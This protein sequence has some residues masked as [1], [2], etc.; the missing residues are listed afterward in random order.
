MDTV[1]IYSITELKEQFPEGYERAYEKWKEYCW[2]DIFW[3]DEIVESFKKTFEYAGISIYDWSLGAYSSCHVRFHNPS[4][5]EYNNE[6]DCDEE[7]EW[8]EL[9]GKKAIDWLNEAFDIFSFEKVDYQYDGKNYQRIDFKK[10]GGEEWSCEFT[11]YC[12]DHD[13]LESLYFEILSGSNLKDAFYNLPSVCGKLL[14]Q[15]IEN[16]QSEDYFL[17]HAEANEY[18]YFENGKRYS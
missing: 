10:K 5:Y 11:G 6:E 4:H 9:E 3:M 15:E 17:D 2:E 18:Q 1:N 14:E 8:G 16:Q 13:Y 7:V 12:A